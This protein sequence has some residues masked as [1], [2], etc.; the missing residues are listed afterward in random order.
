MHPYCMHID[1]NF[2]NYGNDCI[3]WTLKTAYYR[4]KRTQIKK[5]QAF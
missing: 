4:D 1:N 5:K 3:D 2:V